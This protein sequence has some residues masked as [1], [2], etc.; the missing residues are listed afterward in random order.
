MVADY[1]STSIIERTPHT[2][3]P[4]A[5]TPADNAAFDVAM[6]HPTGGLPLTGGNI[7]AGRSRSPPF[8]AGDTFRPESIFRLRGC[9]DLRLWEWTSQRRECTGH[10]R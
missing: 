2:V 7:P 9:G 6:Y 4:V 1:I 5:K 3:I 10:Q 8:A